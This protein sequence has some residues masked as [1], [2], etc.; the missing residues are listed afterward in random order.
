MSV[1]FSERASGATSTK[2]DGDPDESLRPDEGLTGQ[3]DLGIQ[4]GPRR[5]KPLF[6]DDEEEDEDEEEE[7]EGD[8]AP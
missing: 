1:G 3:Q 4:S 6:S 2:E 5:R 8:I 7:E